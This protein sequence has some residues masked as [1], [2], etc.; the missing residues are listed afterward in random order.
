MTA[1]NSSGC[2]ALYVLYEVIQQLNNFTGA[3]MPVK[4]S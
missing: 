2:I 1:M 4:I 3:K